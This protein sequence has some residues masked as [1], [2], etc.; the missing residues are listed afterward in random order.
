MGH[1]G[2][3]VLQ[4]DQAVT[5]KVKRR[6]AIIKKVV[7]N[8][9]L[10]LL[11]LPTLV[12]F[13]VFHYYPM[14]GVQIAFKNFNPIQGIMGSSWAGF[15]H[16][17][18]FFNSYQF[19]A[20]LK[21][22][23]GLAVFEL[24]MFPI[25][26]IMAL[27]LNQLVSSRFKRIVQTVTYAPHFISVVV[28]V[29]ML[30]LFLSPRNGIINQFIILLGGEPIFFFG[31]PEWFK[32]LFV[33]SGVWQNLGWGMIIYLAALTA[34]SPDL[35]EAAVVD[36]ASKL[37]RIWHVDLPSILPTISIMFILNIGNLMGVG[38][39]KV[40]LMQNSLNISSSEVIQTYVYKTGLLGAQYSY[41]A[42]VGLFNS[43][44]N[45]VF[46]ITF[47]KLAKKAGQSSLW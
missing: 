38:F 44:I 25:P 4:K 7:R 19:W 6:S 5:I 36:G 37:K 23:F 1:Q 28:L 46:L 42:A 22:T 16:F 26:I 11:F 41:A 20:V 31:I 45:F 43:V 30:Y 24:A 33:F 3:T 29:G 12:Y 21:N 40:Y 18:R 35:H 2:G 27:L 13:L 14:Y 47:N 10:Y 17:E 34:V 15:E 8:Y 39:E 32:S 9:D